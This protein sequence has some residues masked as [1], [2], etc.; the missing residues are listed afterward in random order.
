MI[1]E[2][3]TKDALRNGIKIVKAAFN[4]FMDDRALK[5]SASLAYYTIFSLAPLLLLLISMA[6]IFLGKDAIQ[7]K[8]FSEINGMVGNDAAKQIQDMIKHLE[9]S[10]KSTMSVIIGIIT[11]IIGATTVFGEIQESINMI[12]QVKP[13]PKKGWLK[14]VKDRLLSGSLIVTLGFLLLVSLVLN[15]ALLALSER[16]KT[17]LPDI[18]VIV[19]NVINI[20]ISFVVIAVLF[21]VIFK[22]LPDVK[23]AWKDVRSGAIFTAVLFMIGRLLIGIYIEKSGTSSTY[24]AAGSLIVILLWVYYTAA[25]LYFGAEFT[26]AYADF[27]GVKIAPAE[28]AVHIEQKESEQDVDVLPKQ[29]NIEPE[30]S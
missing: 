6:G 1:Q 16:L 18:T 10:G 15:G 14:L 7:G 17:F 3:F 30:K 12:W 8:V 19:F 22:V 5:F 13:K 23:I 28:F 29:H 27:K 25:I 20:V 4:G 11:L 21:G 9:M 24:G 2:Y 26:R